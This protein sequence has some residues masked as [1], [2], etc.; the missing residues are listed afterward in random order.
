MPGFIVHIGASMICPHGGQI[1][2]ITSNIRSTVSN[3]QVVTAADT[4][5]IAGCVFTLPSGQP[6]P[7]VIAKWLAPA[8]R[9][10]INGQPALLNNS[11]GLC[12]SGDQS[13]QGPPNVIVT[14][15][16]VRAS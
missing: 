4:Y 7:C 3:E 6:H 8:T 10:F 2:A 15:L 16:R 5:Q 14:Q 11:A 12:Q 9:V 1:S 13:P